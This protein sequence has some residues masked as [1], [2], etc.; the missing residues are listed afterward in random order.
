VLAQVKLAN[1][2][3]KGYQVK[4]PKIS[5]YRYEKMISVCKGKNK[6]NTIKLE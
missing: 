2:E 6:A 1:S 4:S 5:K 3:G